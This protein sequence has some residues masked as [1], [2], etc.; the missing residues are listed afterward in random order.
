MPVWPSCFCTIW[1]VGAMAIM[2]LPAPMMPM[3]FIVTPASVSAPCT[4]S[5]AR[6]T[7]SLSGCLPN[8]VMSMPRIQSSSEADA[9]V[10]TSQWFKAEADRLGAFFVCAD[11]LGGQA[12]LH[13]RGHVLGVG[14]H[15]DEVPPHARALAVDHRRHVRHR[16]ARG[17]EGDDGERPHLAGGRDVRRLE[18][19]VPAR[20]A[21]VAPVEETGAAPG[22]LVG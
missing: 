20:G 2:R 10:L 5:D 22:A 15:V 18:L 9:I 8:F 11:H 19:G 4:A 3:S 6:S 13:A 7:M 16:D 17:G 12:H 14:G 21:G 1:P